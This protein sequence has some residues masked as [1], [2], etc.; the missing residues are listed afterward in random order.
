MVII[1]CI[2]RVKRA[3]PLRPALVNKLNCLETLFLSTSTD[4]MA[5]PTTTTIAS[6][7]VPMSL[8]LENRAFSLQDLGLCSRRHR[9]HSLPLHHL[10][11]PCS[12]AGSAQHRQHPKGYS[13]LVSATSRC[14]H[15]I[16]NRC[17]VNLW[18]QASICYLRSISRQFSVYVWSSIGFE[19]LNHRLYL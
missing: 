9:Y 11:D 4:R 1:D 13:G 3:R 15:T 16:R 14:V 6:L 19:C 18:I 12:Y 8:K 5:A 7:W 10:R 2:Y 17:L